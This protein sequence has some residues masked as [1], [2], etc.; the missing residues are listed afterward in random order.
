MQMKG[1]AITMGIGAAVGAVAVAMLPKQSAARKLVNK[2]AW[3]VE[4]A[5]MDLADKV[6]NK[7][8]M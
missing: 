7:L 3:K 8:D 5:A 1:W 2:A 4:D 6:S